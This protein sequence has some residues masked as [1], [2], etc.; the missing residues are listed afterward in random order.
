VRAAWQGLSAEGLAKA[1]SGRG[2]QVTDGQAVSGRTALVILPGVYAASFARMV[3]CLGPAL[4]EA[5]LG[6]R[7]VQAGERGEDWDGLFG[8]S[9]DLGGVLFLSGLTVPS[10]CLEAVRRQ[11]VPLVGVAQAGTPPFDAVATDATLAGERMAGILAGRGY[12]RALYLDADLPDLSFGL[13]REGLA[14]G[15][16]RQGLD[17]AVFTIGQGQW[18]DPEDAAPRLEKALAAHG[19]DVVVGTTEAATR[20]F[21]LFALARRLRVPRELAVT[22]FGNELHIAELSHFGLREAIAVRHDWPGL[23]RAAAAR[24]LSRL[25]GDPSPPSAQLLPPTVAEVD[26]LPER[27]ALLTSKDK[28]SHGRPRP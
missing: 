21:L 14:A 18:L 6:L 2:W 27:Q 5:G 22:G 8:A 13:R 3:E 15:A 25:S 24:L 17:L 12:R 10:A 23:A 7:V 1:W 16:S 9:S 19:P 28:T 4:R 20:Q 11:R 26:S